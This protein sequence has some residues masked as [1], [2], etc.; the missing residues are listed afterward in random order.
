[1]RGLKLK[2]LVSILFAVFVLCLPSHV[3][4]AQNFDIGEN[5][6]VLPA[7]LNSPQALSRVERN[8]RRAA[9]KVETPEGHGS[10]SYMTI[11][12]HHIVMTAQHVASGPIGTLYGI[13]TPANETSTGRLVYADESLDVAVILVSPLRTRRPMAY[14]P[15]PGTPEIGITVSYSG[16]PSHFDMLS[17]RGMIVGYES[18]APD[19][20]IAVIMHSYGW[21]GCSGSVVFDT[22]GS[23]VGVL[24]GVSVERFPFGQVQEDLIYLTPSSLIREESIVRGICT[25]SPRP[26]RCES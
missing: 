14:V 4:Y 15:L 23:V 2:S 9:V 5:E 12:G 19:R 18:I 11:D 17:F 22:N 8:I 13:I 25:A 10:G 7:G 20:P 21:F 6:V 16:H 24:W 3:S 1:M 26:A